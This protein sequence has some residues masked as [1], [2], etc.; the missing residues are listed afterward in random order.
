VALVDDV[1]NAG[2][3]AGGTLTALDAA[4]AETVAMGALLVLGEPAGV[5]AARR[6]IPLERIAWLPNAIW[7]PDTCPLCAS[8]LPL[9]NLL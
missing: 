1:I 2:S 3:A 7:T 6:G 8:R 5:L 4:G 9:E